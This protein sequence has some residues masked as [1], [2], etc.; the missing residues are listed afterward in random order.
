MGGWGAVSRF[1]ADDL[2]PKDTAK[3]RVDEVSRSVRARTPDLSGGLIAEGRLRDRVL[4]RLASP[5][6][7]IG[8]V[9]AVLFAA[10][11][12]SGMNWVRDRP[13]VAVG[14]IM[15]ETRIVR[16]PFD[17]VDDAQTRVKREQARQ[18]TPRVYVADTA[19]LD[20]LQTELSTLPKL[21]ASAEKVEQV[22]AAVAKKFAL[23][24][25]SFAAIKSEVANGEASP[26]WAARVKALNNELLR[27]PILSQ[28]AWQKAL[29]EGT[30]AK[31]RLIFDGR[32]FAEVYRN[33]VVSVE[34]KKQLADA[35][36]IVARDAGF[37]GVVQPA[38]TAR[39]TQQA[40]P[41]FTPDD[42]A[43]ATAMN[44]A[45]KAVAPVLRTS[46]RGQVIFQRGEALTAAQMDVYRAELAR[47][48]ASLTPVQDWARYAGTLGVCAGVT[49]AL[50]GYLSLFGPRARGG[51]GG[52]GAG[53][54]GGSASVTVRRSVAMA[55]V[56]AVAFMVAVGGSATVPEFISAAATAPTLLVA[57]LACVAF[58]RRASLAV[59]LLHGL[60]VTLALRLSVGHMAE[61][62]TGIA[63]VVW[64]LKTIR[65]R[66]TIFRS[67]VL[68]SVGVGSAVVV[69]G[70]IERP[71]VPGIAREMLIDAGLA[72]GGAFAVGGF[73]LFL[74][75]QVERLL[76]VTTG[77][78]LVDLR[79]PR[80]PLLRELQQ[81]A[82]GTYNHSLNV[83][84]I[85]EAAAEAIGAD[86]LLTYVGALYHDVG[87]MNKPEYFVENQAGGPNRHD[88]LSPAMSFLIVIGHVKD[89]M[90]LA[91]EFDLPAPL[92]HFIEAH[93]GT[94][95]VEYF[96]HRAMKRAQDAA[97]A[98][99]DLDVHTPD[100]VEYRYPGPRPRIKE[101]A[102]LMIADAVESAAR[103]LGDPT[104]ARIESL[105]RSIAHKRLLD[106]QFD[107]CELTLRELSTIVESIARTVASMYH[108]RVAYPDERG[109]D[110]E[111]GENAAPPAKTELK[112]GPAPN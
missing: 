108:G 78:T 9:V 49:L 93:H 76:D 51:G 109:D 85:G 12:T 10:L 8:V 100:E 19:G 73:L 57:M 55:G 104:P 41:T 39:L 42:A 35:A 37:S 47:Y 6:L 110:A 95:L 16:T 106:G 103:T 101:V 7:G 4:E 22:D 61:L 44:A 40:T 89:G 80:Q 88:R 46:P 27:R 25:D 70:L 63:C 54:A 99:S 83:A 52:G 45:E 66:N 58:G 90:E 91:R 23:T 17:T 112:S 105:V 96:Y 11:C 56:M 33:L 36:A 94:T 64:T 84:A 29:Q 81:R 62:V 79:D 86:T 43:T 68:T 102:I 18:E 15:D 31:V 77:M 98:R 3:S 72:A 30:H 34:D 14:R 87:K 82:P 2:M 5:G 67:S 107:D 13:L 50:L 71:L 26:N 75:P 1:G 32:E 65:D 38:I 28:Q 97:D 48:S 92:R 21:L 59:S 60:L 53:G 24:P 111:A 74:L 20:A 69:C